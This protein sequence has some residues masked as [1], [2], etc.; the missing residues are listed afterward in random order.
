GGLLGGESS[1]HGYGAATGTAAGKTTS[2]PVARPRPAEEP[3]A[4]APHPRSDAMVSGL[5]HRLRSTGERVRV[6][7]F[8]QPGDADPRAAS[9]DRA[10]ALRGR[11]IDE[12]VP[13]HQIE[14]VGTGEVNEAEGLRVVTIV[15]PDLDEKPAD[16]T[17]EAQ[18]LGQAHFLS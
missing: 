11:L 15:E 14:A 8:A 3:K 12:G 13:P 4:R 9:L 17:A 2:R 1:G 7:G 16:V 10:N 18:P 6:E 5:G